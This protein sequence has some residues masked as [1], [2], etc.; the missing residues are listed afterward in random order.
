METL[1]ARRRAGQRGFTLIELLVV[2]IILGILAAVVVF[3][4]GGVGDKGNEAA[5]RIDTRTLRTAAEAHFAQ[6]N[7]YTVD[8]GDWIGDENTPSADLNEEALVAAGLM[9]EVSTLH[10]GRVFDRNPDVGEIVPA[11]QVTIQDASTTDGTANICGDEEGHDVGEH[12]DD[13]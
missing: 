12:E 8:A 5:C 2:I 11:F 6:F 9:S 3:A 4:V 13:F 1:Q 7:D 10:D